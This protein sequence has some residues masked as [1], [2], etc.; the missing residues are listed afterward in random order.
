MQMTKID[1]L[2]DPLLTL[3]QC[4]ENAQCCQETLRNAAKRGEL[5]ITR[6]SPRR[7][8]VRRSEWERFL[9]REVAAA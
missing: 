9:S 6:I 2:N 7:I 4:A 5:K 1:P 3:K 8:G